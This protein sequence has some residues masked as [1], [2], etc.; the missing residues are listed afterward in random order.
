[1]KE[2]GIERGRQNESER[3]RAKVER[4]GKK[5]AEN[6]EQGREKRQNVLNVRFLKY[7]FLHI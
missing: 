5:M 4:E 3:D 7:F 6:R 2:G 1:M